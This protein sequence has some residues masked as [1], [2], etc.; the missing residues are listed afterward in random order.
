M[1]FL[2]PKTRPISDQSVPTSWVSGAT[3]KISDSDGNSETLAEKSSGSYYTSSIQGIIG[4]AYSLTITT[5]EGWTYQS[6][7]DTLLP[8][9]DFN[10]R[11]EFKLN[12]D[13][14]TNNQVNSA[15]GFN[16][17]LSGGITWTRG[18]S[19]MAMDGYFRIPHLPTTEICRLSWWRSRSR[20]RFHAVDLS[21]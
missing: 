15:N 6:V 11:Y 13:P 4:R 12:E 21:Q 9:G 10:L 16:I 5:K 20:S 14:Q 8:V 18:Q 19:Y 2:F 3:V 1:W 7:P 17:Y